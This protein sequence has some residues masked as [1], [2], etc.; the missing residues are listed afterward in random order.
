MILDA[1]MLVKSALCQKHHQNGMFNMAMALLVL[2]GTTKGKLRLLAPV[3]RATSPA[4]LH[5]PCQYHVVLTRSRLYINMFL[6][7]PSRKQDL[8]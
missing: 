7:S 5:G 1:Y 6:P 3:N 4:E 2:V 8:A